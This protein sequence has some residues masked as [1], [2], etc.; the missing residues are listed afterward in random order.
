MELAK[1]AGVNITYIV[2]DL[3]EYGT[4]N[5]N[6]QFDIV[7]LEGGI[8]HYFSDLD[9]LAQIIY[10]ILE[11]GGKLV[12]NDFHPIRK[13]LQMSDDDKLILDGDYFDNEVKLG[14]VAYKTHFSGEEQEDFPDC[15]LRYWTTGE[16]ITAF[17]QAGFVIGKLVEEP[18]YDSYKNIPGNFTMIAH[19]YKVDK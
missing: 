12:L 9:L 19:K 17:A 8:L 14:N 16:I 15:L 1:E 6:N 18:R 13:I 10:N 7:Y 3:I 5:S 11:Y 2:S 4:N